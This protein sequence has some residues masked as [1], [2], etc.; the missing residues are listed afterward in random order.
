MTISRSFLTLSFLAAL[1]PATLHA[2]SADL[3][4][5]Y[6]QVRKI[7]LRDPGVRAAYAKADAKLNAKILDI[8]PSLKPI[9]EKGGAGTASAPMAK[10]AAPKKA[11]V[12]K[13][14]QGAAMVSGSSY[15]VAK[16]DTLT[17]IAARYRVTAA[18]LKSANG[19]VDERK[20]RIGQTLR[21]PAHSTARPATSES[22]DGLWARLK[23]GR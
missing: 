12:K 5:E 20:L 21:I 9:V 19:I 18:D 11:G 17:S 16:G 10:S 22:D 7:A 15:V 1:F 4:A 2:A 23:G 6:A 14:L 13:P 3:Q 8:D